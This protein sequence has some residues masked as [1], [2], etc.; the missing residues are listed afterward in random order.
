[1]VSPGRLGNDVVRGSA[2][3]QGKASVS[4]ARTRGDL[5]GLVQPDPL[6]RFTEGERAGTTRHAS[7]NDFDLGWTV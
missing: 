7:A 1:V 6:S 4:T 3:A 2:A 5:A